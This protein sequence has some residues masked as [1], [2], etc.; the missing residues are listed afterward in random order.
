M[1]N[2]GMLSVR[3]KVVREQ[4]PNVYVNAVHCNTFACVG[5]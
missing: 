2:G 1:V 3:P 4:G 5:M